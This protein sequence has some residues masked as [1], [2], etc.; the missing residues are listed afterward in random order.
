[1]PHVPLRSSPL[2]KGVDDGPLERIVALAPPGRVAA[3]LDL[4]RRFSGPRLRVLVAGEA[5]RGKSTLIN[6]LLAT[7]LLPTGAVPVTAVA[8]TVLPIAE[9]V[10]H[11]EVDFLDA[12]TERRPLAD[13]ASLVTEAL[14]PGNIAG[15][16]EVRV[17]VPTATVGSAVELVDTP[18]TGS[19]WQHNTD[20]ATAA[21]ASLDA[22]IVV[23][24]AD[25]P[26]S[27]ADVDLL[28]ALQAESLRTFVFVNKLDRVHG[29]DRTDVETFTRQVCTGT[30]LAAEQVWFGS[31]REPDDGFDGFCHAFLHYV[32]SRAAVD[33]GRALARHARRLLN[34]LL[35]DAELEV[36]V[37]DTAHTAGADRARDL[38][39]RVRA[40]RGDAE[41]LD[42]ECTATEVAL[43]D[44]LNLT[45]GRLQASVVAEVVQALHRTHH[46]ADEGRR[47][48]EELTTPAVLAWRAQQQTHLEARLT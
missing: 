33:A 25:P 2:P 3:A 46:D 26:A 28:A 39:A 24:A 31:A 27:R 14:N 15:V 40:I 6:R 5:K 19:V 20:A 7:D 12:R 30:G 18:G 13:L 43:H 8:T 23:L 4:R 9:G 38:A 45:A 44:E 1:M 35:G 10:G 37:L 21:F 11:L 41:R 42:A 48:V 47:L 36:T 29:V 34:T 17:T 16:R 32:D 22:V